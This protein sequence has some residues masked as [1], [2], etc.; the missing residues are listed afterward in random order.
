MLAWRHEYST[1][2]RI[3]DGP[4]RRGHEPPAIRFRCTLCGE[5]CRRYIPLVT[6]EDVQRIRDNLHRRL[7]AFLT[8]Y[9]VSD[10][11]EGSIVE[12]DERM[13]RTRSGMR[14]LGLSRREEACIF[15][16]DNLCSIHPF[17]PLVCQTYPFDPVDAA[18]PNG[19]F[20]LFQDPCWGYNAADEV[21]DE[22]PVR[23][24]YT[25]FTD[26]EDAYL[27][28]VKEWNAT[29]RSHEASP[30]EFLAYLGLPAEE[31]GEKGGNAQMPMRP[32][33][34]AKPKPKGR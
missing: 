30:S 14:L 26:D 21:M 9:G 27:Q 29:P 12:S 17:K 34:K 18:Q 16:K 5:C 7:S 19:P 3:V 31:T 10:F 28:R 8:L 24:A 23:R 2:G 15:L 13:F 22:A 25:A 6:A 33:P 32:K 11:E 1:R 20:Q 4:H